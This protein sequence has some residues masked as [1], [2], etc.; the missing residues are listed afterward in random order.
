MTW[1]MEGELTPNRVK[2]RWRIWA[3][4]RRPNPLE[5]KAD[6]GLYALVPRYFFHL[7]ECGQYI[8]DDE[9]QELEGLEAA[10]RQALLEAR[11]VM[12]AEVQSG[13]LC[14]S[15]WIEVIDCADRP[16]MKVPFKDAL[17]VSGL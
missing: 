7:H 4:R 6:P 15:C 3:R 12:A 1:A 5:T 11:H 9:G 14:L 17:V 10:R 13:K 16:V 2:M 8:A